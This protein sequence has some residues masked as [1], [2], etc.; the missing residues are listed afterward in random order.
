M[1]Q[2]NIPGRNRQKC[3]TK[4]NWARA[5]GF[6]PLKGE[7][8]IISNAFVYIDKDGNEIV[9]PGIKAGDGVTRLAELP[10]IN[11]NGQNIVKVEETETA[12]VVT[13]SDGSTM[14]IKIPQKGVDYFTPED[15]EEFLAQLIKD[16]K[17]FERGL[18]GTFEIPPEEWTDG[19]PTSALAYIPIEQHSL[20]LLTPADLSTLDACE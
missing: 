11:T 6:I 9:T 10:Y 2:K 4:E 15:Q 12:I 17:I 13:L 19:T 16:E 14:E 20:I 5:P 1:A 18:S 8:I 7:I 3:D